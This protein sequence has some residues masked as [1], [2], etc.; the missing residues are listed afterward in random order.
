MILKQR[1]M[2]TS[3]K[4]QSF[5]LFIGRGL[6]K[7]QKRCNLLFIFML[8][9]KQNKKTDI[10]DSYNVMLNGCNFII[11]CKKKTKKQYKHLHTKYLKIETKKAFIAS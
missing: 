11:I 3:R 5:Q 7:L 2:Q 6:V 4:G 10:F 8:K 9:N 1:R